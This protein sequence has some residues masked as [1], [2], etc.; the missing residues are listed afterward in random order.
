MSKERGKPGGD[1]DGSGARG[2]S[3]ELFMTRLAEISPRPEKPISPESRL[4]ADLG[5][6]SLAFSRLALLLYERYGVGAISTASLRANGQLT[7]K[8]FFRTYVV[9]T[10]TPE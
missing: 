10:G 1:L 2:Y 8:S 5:F 6:D 7:V 4:V 3:L 9:G